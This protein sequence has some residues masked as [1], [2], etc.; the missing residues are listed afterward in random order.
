MVH[1]LDWPDG[2]PDR[3]RSARRGARSR[4][5]PDGG[6]GRAREAR[7][8]PAALGA[9]PPAGPG[10]H[11]RRTVSRRCSCPATP[12]ARTAT[13]TPSTLSLPRWHSAPRRPSSYRPRIATTGRNRAATAYR[14]RTSD[15]GFYLTQG[16]AVAL[17]GAAWNT[18]G[19][20]P[21]RGPSAAGFPRIAVREL[22][23][24]SSPCGNRHPRRPGE[25]RPASRS[26]QPNG[27]SLVVFETWHLSVMSSRAPDCGDAAQPQRSHGC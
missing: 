20:W 1:V 5:G 3:D 19:T 7:Y 12:V 2:H 18:A 24:P 17:G 26:N 11:P 27:A 22:T 15:L 13:S 16:Y 23:S 9:L 8:R 6:G 4:V 21:G 14:S 10:R 25:R